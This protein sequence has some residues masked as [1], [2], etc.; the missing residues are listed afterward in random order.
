MERKTCAGYTKVVEVENGDLGLVETVF[1]VFGNIDEGGDIIHPGAFTK[2]IGE[3][4]HKVRVL[5]Q[6]QAG[7]IMNAIGKPI[8]MRELQRSELPASLLLQFPDAS[9]GAWARV[10]FLMSTPE[11]KGAFERIKTGIVDEWSFGYDPVVKDYSALMAN[12]ES[13]T[14]RNLR[15]VKLYELSP[16]LWGMNTA[17]QT[18]SAKAAA[19]L[20]PAAGESESDFMG[21]CV[22]A[23]LDEGREQDQA[24][25]MCLSMFGGK[26]KAARTEEDGEHP[27]SH[28]LVVEDAEKPATWHLRV[29][30]AEGNLDHR[31]M[32]AAWA[33]LHGGYRGNV[34]EG[35]GKDEAISKL[36]R[37]Y[38]DEEMDVPGKAADDGRETMDDERPGEEAKAGRVLAKRN[39]ERIQRALAEINDVLK[40]AGLLEMDEAEEEAAPGK[41]A[42]T[43]G[44]GPVT[45]PTL[46]EMLRA[47]DVELLETKYM[48]V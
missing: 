1:A 37:L 24:V 3:R 47:I 41:A 19:K 21:R 9:G 6:H 43:P 27:A 11:G 7:S 10:Q 8:A 13:R 22:P 44:A 39:V 46:D 23:M 42:A 38:A 4:G 26:A 12:G 16:V 30:D 31:L 14:V 5:D 2:T 32:G 29:R 20:E 45:P 18:V 34:Y 33:A 48:E 25:A 17:T 40:D 28:Y 15:E 36:T 35:P